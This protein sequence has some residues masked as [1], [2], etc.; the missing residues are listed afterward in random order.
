MYKD[1]ISWKLLCNI[2]MEMSLRFNNIHIEDWNLEYEAFNFNLNQITFKSRLA[3]KTPKKAGYFVAFWHKDEQYKNVPFSVDESKDKLLINIIDGSKQGQ[4]I[5]PK[6][7]LQ[8][9]GILKSD[10]HNGK[11]A[12]R[13]YP[14]WEV[15]LNQSALKT[16]SWQT[17]YFVNM[18]DVYHKDEV[19]SLY[20]D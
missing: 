3:K 7:M 18:S 14:S 16:Q 6:E 13:V 15:D 9:K 19:L 5:F 11:M 8:T 12:M 1:Y 10:Q 20:L 2:Q 17:P 4:F